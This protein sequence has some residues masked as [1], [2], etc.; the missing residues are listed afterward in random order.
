MSPGWWS[1][2]RPE[3]L[4]F[5]WA[6]AFRHGPHPR[7]VRRVHRRAGGS[8]DGAASPAS[9]D[10]V[11]DDQAAALPVAAVAALGSLELLALVPGQR[12][13]VMGAAG[14]VGGYAVQM[15]VARG[16]RVRA[17]VRSSAMR[18]S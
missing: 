13:V 6:I 9:P 15:A 4:I 5:T 12:L 2:F 7:V 11:P 3:S 14:G 8:Q 10:S 17:T 16:A 1:L 18:S